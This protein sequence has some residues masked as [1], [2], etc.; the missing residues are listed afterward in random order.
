MIKLLVRMMTDKLPEYAAEDVERALRKAGIS[1]DAVSRETN[2]ELPRPW[3]FE[4]EDGTIRCGDC[5]MKQKTPI[6]PDDPGDAELHEFWSPDWIK[7]PRCAD[8]R[9][10]LPVFLEEAP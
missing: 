7:A 8:C 5:N 2:E 10:S 1:A 4:L 6:D 9:L 3:F